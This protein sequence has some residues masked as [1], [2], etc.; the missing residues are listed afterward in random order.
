MPQD[1]KQVRGSVPFLYRVSSLYIFSCP[2]DFT[3]SCPQPFPRSSSPPLRVGFSK[4]GQLKPEFF[5][6]RPGENVSLIKEMNVQFIPKQPGFR[7]AIP[8]LAK[9]ET[10]LR[11]VLKPNFVAWG[12]LPGPITSPPRSS[13][14]HSPTAQASPKRPVWAPKPPPVPQKC[15][16]S[17]LTT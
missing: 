8:L 17:I 14:L 7:A 5:T 15:W 10:G 1:S 6:A 2:C 11:R 3:G 16:G 13:S 12:E 9:N 4:C